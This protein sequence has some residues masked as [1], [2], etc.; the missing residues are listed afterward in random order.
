[1]NGRIRLLVC[2]I[3]GTLVRDD[4]SLSDGVIAAVERV[5]NAGLAMSLISARPP[6][7]MLWIAQR[8]QIS[9]VM[10]AFNGGT[11]MRSDGTIVLSEH[12]APNCAARAIALIDHPAVTLWLFAEGQWFAQTIDEVYVPLERQAA[13]IEP[14]LRGHFDGLLARVDK[15]VGVSG[16][17]ELLARLD[18]E[19]SSALGAAATVGRSQPYYLDITAPGANKG[20]GLSALAGATGVPLDQVAVIG[21]QRNDMPMFARAGLSIAMGQAPATVRTAASLVTLS[22][23]EDGVAHAIESFILAK[24]VK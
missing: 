11:L 12:I 7:G 18:K 14:V 4:K 3:D 8:L 21:D 22:N 10:G 23:E 17:R 16:D 9:D 19:I 6:S 13:N 15:I 2:D 5:R 24:A 20:D 1:M